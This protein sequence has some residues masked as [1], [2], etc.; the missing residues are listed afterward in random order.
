MSY[1][2]VGAFAIVFDDRVLLYLREEIEGV[3]L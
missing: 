1:F 3:L 2:R